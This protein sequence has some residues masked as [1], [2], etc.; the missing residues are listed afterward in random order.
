MQEFRIKNYF[1]DF[2]E[3]ST[4]NESIEKSELSESID[5]MGYYEA[6]SSFS[7]KHTKLKDEF[8]WGSIFQSGDGV[9]HCYK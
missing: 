7:K 4:D 8:S 9:F 3:S 1:V 6:I 5:R 2:L